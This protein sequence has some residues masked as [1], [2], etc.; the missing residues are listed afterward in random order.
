MKEKIKTFFCVLFLLCT[1]P[2][3]I[4]MCFRQSTAAEEDALGAPGDPGQG[5]LPTGGGEGE[6]AVDVEEYLAGVLARE[7]P[8]TYE[9]EALKAQAVIARTNIRSA[10]EKGEEL[11]ESLTQE[12]LLELWGE[13]GFGGNYQKLTEAV[14]ATEGVTLTSQ[15]NYI[16][17]AFHAVSAGRTRSGAEALGTEDMPY[18]TT[19]ESAGDI[20]SQDFLKVIFLEKEEFVRRLTAAFPNLVLEAAD[21]LAGLAVT[22]R[23]GSDYVLEVKNGE[24]SMS[25]E[26]FRNA[27]ELSSACFSMKEVEGRIRIVTKGLGHGLG[28]SQYGANELAKE[29]MKYPEILSYYFKNVEISD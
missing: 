6:E 1:L 29:G 22:A 8:L 23:D 3:I 14:R 12:K 4:T 27:L 25:G 9:A 11:P 2:Y 5:L 15:G 18:L 17:A 28:L 20:S 19:V 24:V 13:E 21:P 16:Y 26:A 7:I 10:L